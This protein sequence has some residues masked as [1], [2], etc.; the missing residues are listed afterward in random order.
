M[1]W[2]NLAEDIVEELSDYR[3][4][5]SEENVVWLRVI[6]PLANDNRV[7]YLKDYQKR[8]AAKV[9][10]DPDKA[11][12]RRAQRLASYHRNKGKGRAA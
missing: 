4:T 5:L 1:S 9:A 10:A 12:K 6:C 2:E 7:E 8:Y 11:A 3:F